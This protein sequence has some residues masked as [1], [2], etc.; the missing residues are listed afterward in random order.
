MKFPIFFCIFATMD[1]RRPTFAL[2]GK[3]DDP[4]SKSR[5]GPFILLLNRSLDEEN[6]AI[7]NFDPNTEFY[8]MSQV[9]Q[10]SIRSLRE[11]ETSFDFSR[12]IK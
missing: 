3:I 8:R 12:C 10:L 5:G 4:K 2:I 11:H 6:R 7:F 1:N 9:K